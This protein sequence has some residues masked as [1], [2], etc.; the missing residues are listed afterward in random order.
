M[1][2]PRRT[3]EHKFEDISK[4]QLSEAL[5]NF[6]WTTQEIHPDYGEDLYVAPFENGNP[7]GNEFKI[8]AK[9]TDDL[10][11]YRLK[12]EN[13]VFSYP[14]SLANLKQWH[15]YPVPV[16]VILWDIKSRIGHWLYIQPF[17]NQKLHKDPDWLKN[18]SKAEK[19]KRY[20]YIPEFQFIKYD[21]I[22]LL[23]QAI[24]KVWS[25]KRKAESHFNILYD[26]Y[27][28]SQANSGTDLPSHI[29][30]QLRINELKAL[31][32]SQPD[33]LDNWLE[34]A[35][36]FYK[37]HHYKEGLRVIQ[38]AW[39]INPEHNK[40]RWIK[41]CIQAEYFT[42]QEKTKKSMIDEA[43]KLFQ[44]VENVLLLIKYYCIGNCY[45]ALNENQTALE[46]YNKALDS[47]NPKSDN[48]LTA[49]IW[50]NR[51]NSLNK[52]GNTKEAIIS[53]K[54]AIGLNPSN[55][56]AYSSLAHIEAKLNNHKN[57]CYYFEKLF[58]L[59]PELKAD[60]D[61]HLYCYSRS[62]CESKRYREALE[63][64]DLLLIVDPTD[65][66]AISLKVYIISQLLRL[67]DSYI[68]EALV[69]L[70]RCL[71]DNPEDMPV[72]N[73]LLTIY[74]KLGQSQEVKILL[75]ETVAFNNAP[76]NL[77]YNYAML[78]KEGSQFDEAILLLERA[79][80]IDQNHAIIHNLAILYQHQKRYTEAIEKYRFAIDDEYISLPLLSA[81][82]DCFYLMKDYTS[83]IVLLAK[84][85][86]MGA[87]G[88]RFKQKLCLSLEKEKIDY[89]DFCIFLDSLSSKDVSLDELSIRNEFILFSK[90]INSYIEDYYNSSELD[91]IGNSDDLNHS[92]YTSDWSQLRDQKLQEMGYNPSLDIVVDEEKHPGFD[93][94]DEEWADWL[95]RTT[96]FDRLEA[97]SQAGLSAIYKLEKQK[98]I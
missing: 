5:Q 54:K 68:N 53:C 57:A 52:L 18:I 96:D 25:K 1:N 49:S 61:N 9:G 6:G 40:T 97:E 19:P 41:A 73:E 62:L 86:L 64:I 70:K 55:W 27:P 11:I 29:S 95:I 42:K 77:L 58:D 47:D 24:N 85:I 3:E 23:A 2:Y 17:I 31:S 91:C 35:S 89:G 22:E 78:L 87:N 90:N 66:D 33:N 84:I 36:I 69:F 21:N 46:Y 75:E 14:I 92:Q 39:K 43:I 20:I 74:H 81:I 45:S 30:L 13:N 12:T 63:A 82:S 16:I 44:S 88:I 83:D 93:A 32:V 72:R 7:T 56:N 48:E 28:E 34:L 15:R 60:G 71:L 10:N 8:Q 67:D 80:K 51:G 37:T 94:S 76:P 38:N 50:T 59:N 4:S 26:A 98:N 65:D 79:F